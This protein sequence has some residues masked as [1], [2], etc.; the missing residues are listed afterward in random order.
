MVSEVLSRMAKAAPKKIDLRFSPQTF[1][2]NNSLLSADNLECQKALF[3]SWPVSELQGIKRR[4]GGR[5]PET[6][7]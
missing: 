5:T 3:V 1:H 4:L 6:C 7:E 2:E